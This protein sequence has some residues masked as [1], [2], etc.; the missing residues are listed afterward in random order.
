ML[1]PKK[2]LLH[3]KSLWSFKKKQNKKNP[4]QL[5]FYY[6]F[7]R[8]LYSILTLWMDHA[9]RLACTDHLGGFRK[10]GTANNAA[11]FWP[12]LTSSVLWLCSTNSSILSGIMN[13][14]ERC[15]L[16]QHPVRPLLADRHFK[17]LQI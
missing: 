8:L 17:L 13:H 2:T 15:R 7:V 4:T 11:L 9:I 10:A 1:K 6:R 5:F 14:S 12:L 16:V 3:L